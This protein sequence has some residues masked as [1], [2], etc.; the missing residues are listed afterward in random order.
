MQWEPAHRLRAY[1]EAMLRQVLCHARDSSP[2][3]QDRIQSV[4]PRDITEALTSVPLLEKRDL[5]R[6]FDDI[7]SQEETGRVSRKTTG[8]STGEPVTITKNRTATAYERAAMWLAYGWFGVEMG[9]RAARFWGTPYTWKRR[10]TSRLGD[11]CMNRIRF[12]AFEFDER[13]LGEYWNELVQ[14]EPDYIHGYV[15]MLEQMARWAIR[16]D[17]SSSFKLKSVVATSE[18]LTEP[19]R[20]VIE[21]GFGAPVQLEYGCGEVGPISHECPQGRLHLMVPNLWV[22]VLKPDGSPVARGESGEIVLTDLHNRSM[23]LIR[24]RVGDRGVLGDECP[25]GRTFPVLERV[26]GRAY[27]FVEAPS[28]QRYHGE[29]FMYLFE[30]LRSSGI[31]I[32]QFQVIQAAPD[33]LTILLASERPIESSVHETIVATLSRRLPGMTATVKQVPEIPRTSSGKMQVIK[34]QD[35][36][37]RSE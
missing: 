3:Y 32:A 11:L 24:Y 16:E 23:P 12:S 4:L 28:G 14:F 13:R 31:S 19:Q 15:S 25:C 33:C 20:R 2:F 35:L 1:Q 18:V 29:F 7:R 8:G 26:W 22:E 9:D 30:D 21:E 6:H 37:P 5:Q 36:A 34:R 10:I 27:D 17:S